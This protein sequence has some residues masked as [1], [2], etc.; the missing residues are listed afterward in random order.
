MTISATRSASLRQALLDHKRRQQ[1]D[2]QSRVREGRTQGTREVG[3]TLDSS[4]ADIQSG[5]DFAL[6]QM[7]SATLSRID[8]ALARLNAGQYGTCSECGEDISERR[9][10]ALPFAVRCH[11]CEAQREAEQ[12]HPR[13]LAQPRDRAD[14]F[15]ENTRH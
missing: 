14:L 11:E 5:L 12:G 13:T 3:D 15:P 7:R 10:R 9:L 8:E 2:V 6:L 1:G 4:D